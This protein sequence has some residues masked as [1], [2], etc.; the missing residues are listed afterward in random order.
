MVRQH[1]PYG[2]QKLQS[3]K[4][5]SAARRAE[6]QQARA[7]SKGLSFR[8]AAPLQHLPISAA[9]GTCAWTAL[10]RVDAHVTW[11]DYRKGNIDPR[12]RTNEPREESWLRCR[13]QMQ[14]AI[15]MSDSIQR[16]GN[17][18]AMPCCW[19]PGTANCYCTDCIRKICSTSEAE[20]P[21]CPACRG[22]IWLEANGRVRTGSEAEKAYFVWDEDSFLRPAEAVAHYPLRR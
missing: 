4:E 13:L 2:K 18:T 10:S 22:S 16:R 20:C 3:R 12:L 14:C 1:I 21:T 9:D 15:C 19:R 7:K 11:E 17:F 6:R 5:K 8:R